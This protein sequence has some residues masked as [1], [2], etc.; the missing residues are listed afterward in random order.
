MKS[1]IRRRLILLYICAAVVEC[2]LMFT[3]SAA[4]WAS[5]NSLTDSYSSNIK[6]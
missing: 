1:G 6:M 4:V 5:A 3:I 2:L